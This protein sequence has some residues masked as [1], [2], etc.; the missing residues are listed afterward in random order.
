MDYKSQEWFTRDHLE[1][2]TLY[3]AAKK[4]DLGGTG[5]T[6]RENVKRLRGGMQYKE[7][8]ERLSELGRPIPPLGLRRI[9]AGERRVDVDDLVALAVA[10][11]VSPLAILL[12]T[13]G[14]HD[15][16]SPLTGVTDREVAHNVQW[17]WA[18]GQEPLTMGTAADNKRFAV[19]SV[20]EIENRKVPSFRPDKVPEN[21]DADEFHRRTR[22]LADIQG[23]RLEPANGDD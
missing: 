22:Y 6:V 11:G 16:A 19:A 23:I 5:E 14:A 12:P 9:E 17:K 7:L 3:M 13:D 8:S 4:L 2:Y 1:R 20:P 10:L 15:L 21:F 18:L